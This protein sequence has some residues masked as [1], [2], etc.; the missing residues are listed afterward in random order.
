MKKMK[1]VKVPAG[2]RDE[3]LAEIF[4]Q[5]LG[6]GTVNVNV[7][8]PRYERIRK[9]LDNLL[10]LFDMFAGSP[11]FNADAAYADNCQEIREFTKSGRAQIERLF[12]VDLK[13]YEWNYNLV[14]DEDR[15]KFTEVYTA[16]K[17]S[18]LV[19]TFIIMCDRLLTYKN[20]IRDANALDHKFISCMPGTSWVPFPFTGMNIKALVD[21]LL[22]PRPGV[23]T[24]GDPTLN[25]RYVLIVLNK[26]YQLSHNLWEEITSPDVD[27]NQFS[28]LIMNNIDAIQRHPKLSRCRQAFQKIKDSVSLLQ[29]RFSGYYRDFVSTQDSTIM[30]QHFIL[31]VSKNTQADPEVTRQFRQIISYYRE[32]AQQQ[33]KNPKVKMLFDKVS[34]SFRELERGTQNLRSDDASDGSAAPASPS[35]SDAPTSDAGK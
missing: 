22:A 19:N 30:M 28:S 18:D 27:V 4:N 25:V 17:K 31:D 5:M 15:A 14:G 1:T 10:K 23:Q 16:C 2:M 34:E 6:A 3:N 12:S 9:T 11:L 21:G 24:V 32:V 26:A 20:Y 35:D 33:I 29:Q 13:A 8:Y 7:A